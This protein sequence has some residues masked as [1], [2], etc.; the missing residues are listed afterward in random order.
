MIRQPVTSSSI[1]SIGYDESTQ[2]LE[3]EFNSGTIYQY[4]DVPS[5]I[6]EGIMNADLHGS[7]GEYF[8]KYIKGI[9]N[10]LKILE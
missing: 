2:T 8:H 10:Y 9:Y 7:Y 3:I 1:S 6:Y 5:T 4:Y